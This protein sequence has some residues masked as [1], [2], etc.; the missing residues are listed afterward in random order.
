L[1][2]RVP[3]SGGRWGGCGG[4]RPEA[5]TKGSGWV[6][7]GDGPG[8]RNRRWWCAARVRV[9]RIGKLGTLPATAGGSGGL[10]V[11]TGPGGVIEGARWRG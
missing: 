10:V 11:V 3:A 6:V 1:D 9:C 7:V 4:G 8:W 5:P 2:I